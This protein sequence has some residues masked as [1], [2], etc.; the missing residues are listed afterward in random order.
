MEWKRRWT[1]VKRGEEECAEVLRNLG[2][3]TLHRRAKRLSMLEQ[4]HSDID[5]AHM[6]HLT[7]FMLEAAC[8]C[9]IDGHF[10]G[11]VLSLAAGVEHGLR[12]VLDE[13]GES[14]PVLAELIEIAVGRDAVD[15]SQAVVLQKLRKYRND[16]AHSNI[17]RRAVGKKLQ[18]QRYVVTERGGMPDSDWEE[19]V[20]E[21]QADK[22]AVVHL[23]EEYEVG[24]LLVEVRE[25]LHDV[26][27]RFPT[28]DG[29]LN[30]DE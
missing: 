1:Q 21:S 26:F 4:I 24:E 13:I 6:P 29:T 28:L 12:Q 22:E 20:P 11:C 2:E 3:R 27:D 14:D 10:T 25:V 9:F 23:S 16:V 19:F 15:S 5:V 8:D 30:T 18:R 7:E 17:G